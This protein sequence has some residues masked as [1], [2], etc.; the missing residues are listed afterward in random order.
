MQKTKVLA[1]LLAVVMV[2]GL[3]SMASAAAPNDKV[4][5]NNM[6]VDASLVEAKAD[7]QAVEEEAAVP[8]VQATDTP[9]FPPIAAIALAGC[10]TSPMD[11]YTKENDTTIYYRIYTHGVEVST[12][13][14]TLSLMLSPSTGYGSTLN[15]SDVNSSN[16]ASIPWGDIGNITLK[17]GT[18][19]ATRFTA[20]WG[21]SQN[22]RKSVNCVVEFDTS[23]S[24]LLYKN[25]TD[26][27]ASITNRDSF[28]VVDMDKLE[29]GVTRYGRQFKIFGT[30]A[31]TNLNL[32]FKLESAGADATLG[33]ATPA[34]S[35]ISDGT[36]TI[37]FTGVDLTSPKELVITNGTSS[38][39][40]TISANTSQ[41]ITVH[42]AIRTYLA[43]E[44]INGSTTYYDYAAKG[45]GT[46]VGGDNSESLA[47]LGV[48]DNYGEPVKP[49]GPA[50]ANG[51]YTFDTE[52]YVDIPLTVGSSVMDALVAYASDNGITLVGANNNYISAM[53][54][55]TNMLSEFSCGNGSGWMYTV[56]N[57]SED[58]DSPLPNV[59]A[60]Y[61]IVSNGQYIDWYYTAAYGKDFGYSIFDL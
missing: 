5:V 35:A 34:T 53:G 23:E 42:F 50:D 12:E 59:G 16:T 38:H 49:Q 20:S 52:T 17:V 41:T 31:A 51:R 33:S 57:T 29:G 13:E 2:L 9:V 36:K 3:C 24:S 30:E 39:T 19:G 32:Q 27:G 47:A 22:L 46:G 58:T 45:F 25:G 40:Y 7:A 26:L 14:N 43:Y 4:Q 56:R 54:D 8:A 28:E 15:I 61:K 55:G 21:V 10:G 1:I 18:D 37:T 11:V 60:S 48:I 44:W 6:M